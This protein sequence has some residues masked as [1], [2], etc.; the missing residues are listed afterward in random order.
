MTTQKLDTDLQSTTKMIPPR[1]VTDVHVQDFVANDK[2]LV[3]ILKALISAVHNALTHCTLLK[4]LYVFSLC[5]AAAVS[6]TPT[7]NGP[8]P[9]PTDNPQP[10]T[11]CQTHPIPCEDHCLSCYL[12]ITK[13][14]F[15]CLSASLSLYRDSL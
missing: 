1:D 5:G 8:P 15:I 6:V 4:M 9:A 10:P 13:F 2:W 12:H 11:P 14:P 3:P 7:N